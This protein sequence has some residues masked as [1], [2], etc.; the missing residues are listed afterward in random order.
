ML[1]RPSISGGTVPRKASG[2]GSSAARPSHPFAELVLDPCAAELTGLPDNYVG[3]TIPFRIKDTFTL[4]TNSSGEAAGIANPRF[5]E[6]FYTG[7]FTSNAVSAW[8]TAA[9]MDKSVALAADMKTHRILAGCVK[10]QYIGA[11]QTAAGR[12][13][14]YV[15]ENL[16][17]TDL[18]V[19][20]RDLMNDGVNGRTYEVGEL[21]KEV[22]LAPFD[23]PVFQ[24]VA[25]GGNN[26]FYFPSVFIG[27]V[28]APVST[29]CLSIE[30]TL[31][32]EYIPVATGLSINSAQMYPSHPVGLA[33][34]YN[35]SGEKHISEGS[36]KKRR[37]MVDATFQALGMVARNSGYPMLAKTISSTPMAMRAARKTV[38]QIAKQ[39]KV[40]KAKKSQA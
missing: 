8:G 1:V 26:Y 20:P 29:L 4:T 40:R 3:R 38:K 16:A 13:V 36:L 35:A 11:D 31:I 33:A 27:L 23:G 6:G 17:T 22:R 15:A 14:M 28:G 5:N 18:Q 12:V 39:K 32:L 10:V 2:T 7:T 21:P 19:D 37:D 9:A 30:F 25:N 34:A 24:T